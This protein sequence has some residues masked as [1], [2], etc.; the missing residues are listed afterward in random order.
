MTPARPS[1]CVRIRALTHTPALS[2]SGLPDIG[3]A[4]FRRTI[5][6]VASM[7]V[8]AV[9]LSCNTPGLRPRELGRSA[10]RDLAGTLRRADLGCSGTD[11]FV[12]PRHLADPPHSERAVEAYLGALAF[13]LDMADLIGAPPVL[14]T[15]L[16]RDDASEQAIRTVA[17]EADRL[18]VTIADLSL[19]LG[20]GTTIAPGLDPASLLQRDEDPVTTGAKLAKTLAIARLSDADEGGRCP[21]GDG[22]L[23]AFAYLLSLSAGGYTGP[24]VIDVRALK[25]PWTGVEA[26]VRAFEQLPTPGEPL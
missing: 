24:I 18:G 7:R 19:P 23:D 10:R 4:T 22:H 26:G 11:L 3:A 8:R 2:L 20:E 6:R 14:T 5:D 25:D 21:V 15:T 12:P 9:S 1:A 17:S 16:P 13:A